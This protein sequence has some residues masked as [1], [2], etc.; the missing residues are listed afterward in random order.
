MWTR[1]R[2]ETGRV[3]EKAPGG[4]TVTLA[5]PEIGHKCLC[6]G[7]FPILVLQEEGNWYRLTMPGGGCT[8]AAE[9]PGPCWEVKLSGRG[10]RLALI[11]RACN[12][13]PYRRCPR[14]PVLVSPGQRPSLPAFVLVQ[15][16]CSLSCSR[17]QPPCPC[18]QLLAF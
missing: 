15:P 11:Q 6:S 2:K 10:G 17:E 12:P 18:S 4:P 1:S 7:R 13:T 5:D 16:P 8:V 9:L 14:G 3:E